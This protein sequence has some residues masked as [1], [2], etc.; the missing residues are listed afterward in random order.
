M[1]RLLTALFA[2]L[3]AMPAISASHY[4]VTLAT[5]C[6]DIRLRLF[7]DTPLHRD[8]FLR[9]VRS[10]YYD[11]ASF[12]R[13]IRDF[14]IQGGV[15][16]PSHSPS[17][18]LKKRITT[19]PSDTIPA[20]LRFPSHCHRRGALAAAREGDDVNPTLASSATEF[21]I[22]WGHTFTPEKLDAAFSRFGYVDPADPQAVPDSVR[23]IYNNVGG[24]PHLDGGYTVFGEVLAGLDIVD[25]IQRT[26]TDAADCPLEPVVIVKATARRVRDRRGH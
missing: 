20:E 1:P 4:E 8:N 2:C 11:G 5:N 17:P 24:T 26:A 6:G 15:D 14:M 18:R 9:L 12:Y 7:D 10:H 22:V 23:S 13:V 21:Y 19:L 25:R 16:F 3:L